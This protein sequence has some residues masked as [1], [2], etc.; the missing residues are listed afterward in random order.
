MGGGRDLLAQV[1]ETDFDRAEQFTVGGLD[2][3][4]DHLVEER[5]GL[6][7]ELLAEVVA[8]LVRRFST[9]SGRGRAQS[10]SG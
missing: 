10:G 9:F 7:E 4:V 1:A 2:K 3:G 5:K 6:G 8:T